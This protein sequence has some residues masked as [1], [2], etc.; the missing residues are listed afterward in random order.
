MVADLTAAEYFHAA[1]A[2][3]LKAVYR[4]LNAKAI[5][6]KKSTEVTAVFCA[7]AVLALMLA[8]GLSLLWFHRVA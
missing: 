2:A 5:L 1:T 6:E 8:W 4:N 7:A 3:E